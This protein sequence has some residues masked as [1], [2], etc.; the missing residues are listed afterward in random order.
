M[1]TAERFEPGPK[2]PALSVVKPHLSPS[3]ARALRWYFGE[4]QCV[5][6]RS[7]F[8]ASL[9]RAEDYGYYTTENGTLKRVPKSVSRLRTATR[10]PPSEPTLEDLRRY[11]YVSRRLRKLH[12]V[13]VGT[14]GIPASI[15]LEASEGLLGDRAGG[16]PGARLLALAHLTGPGLR[17]VREVQERARAVEMRIKVDLKLTPEEI[18][19]LR[20]VADPSRIEDKLKSV[21]KIMEESPVIL[22]AD[23]RKLEH[24]EAS[25]T[26]LK[27][28]L[29]RK[30][31]SKAL[32][33]LRQA[34]LITSMHAHEIY[35]N[36]TAKKD[37]RVLRLTQ[38]AE[39]EAPKLYLA[40]V[41]AWNR[42]E[43]S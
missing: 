40:A 33:W 11:A 34:D 32:D 5:F 42:L 7:T 9:Q 35:S 29:D 15:V 22:E 16:R 12:S 6:E 38:L 2:K 21:K 43:G 25:L 1:M 37:P 8:G 18:K 26:T 19:L 31:A 3:D 36:E 24:V 23:K 27:K 39:Q 20:G 30:E 17:L 41:E 28:L 10:P 13:V 14:P 4:G